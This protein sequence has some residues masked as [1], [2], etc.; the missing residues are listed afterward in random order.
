MQGLRTPRAGMDKPY[1]TYGT[2]T[3]AR[4]IS[5]L[6]HSHPARCFTT[7]AGTFSPDL[8]NATRTVR[9]PRAGVYEPYGT[10]GTQTDARG[11]PSPYHSRPARCFTTQAGTFSLDL[12]NAMR[13]VRTPRA[14]MDESYGTLRTQNH[15]RGIPSPCHSRPARIFTTQAGTYPPDLR[16]ATRTVRTPPYGINESYGT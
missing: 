9:T 4:G 13:T 12:R 16:N 10:Y 5:S 3:D 11:I 6:C 2:Q 14:G 1:G 8:R 15:A 7:Q